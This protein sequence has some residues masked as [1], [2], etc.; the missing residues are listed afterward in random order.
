MSFAKLY[1]M[2]NRIAFQRKCAT[3][4]KFN[5]SNAAQ[6]IKIFMCKIKRHMGPQNSPPMNITHTNKHNQYYLNSKRMKQGLTK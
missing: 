2:L 5:S 3:Q 4:H 1:L 6:F